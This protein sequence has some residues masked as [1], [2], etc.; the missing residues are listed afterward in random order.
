[1]I[2]FEILQA[3]FLTL[4]GVLGADMASFVWRIVSILIEALRMLRGCCEVMFVDARGG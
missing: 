2:S 4:V 1:M 3:R